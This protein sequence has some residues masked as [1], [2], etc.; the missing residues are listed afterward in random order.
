[1]CLIKECHDKYTELFE[2]RWLDKIDETNQDEIKSAFLKINGFYK[3]SFILLS[4]S[5]I[6]GEYISCEN[7]KQEIEK[8][9]CLQAKVHQSHLSVL[10]FKPS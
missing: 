8:F 9:V 1:M 3:T 6:S 5:A 7:T 2:E 10:Y 4:K